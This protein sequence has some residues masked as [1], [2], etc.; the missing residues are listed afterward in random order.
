MQDQDYPTISISSFTVQKKCV[1]TTLEPW[2]LQWLT[3]F[4]SIL[5]D[6]YKNKRYKINEKAS[7]NKHYLKKRKIRTITRFFVALDY[8]KS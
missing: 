2:S 1:K 4:S 3:T 7:Q 8:S 6:R 5:I